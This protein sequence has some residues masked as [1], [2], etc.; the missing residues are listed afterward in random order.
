M[1]RA[2]HSQLLCF[3]RER[4]ACHGRYLLGSKMMGFLHP[5]YTEGPM[6]HQLFADNSTSF[7][8]QW[9]RPPHIMVT[10]TLHLAC[11]KEFQNEVSGSCW[12]SSVSVSKW[13]LRKN[14]RQSIRFHPFTFAKRCLR[15]A[16]CAASQLLLYRSICTGPLFASVIR[17]SRWMHRAV[18]WI[19]RHY[20]TALW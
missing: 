11:E 14:S 7:A 5:T 3:S 13:H 20:S 6:S 2:I 9:M 10:S 4:S 18:T 15:L 19:C 1:H 12:Y 16:C 17:P 8:I